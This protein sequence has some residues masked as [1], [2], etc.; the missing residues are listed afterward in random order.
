MVLLGEDGGFALVLEFLMF[1]GPGR[2]M[3]MILA[4]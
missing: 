4:E 3:G 2:T 1:V